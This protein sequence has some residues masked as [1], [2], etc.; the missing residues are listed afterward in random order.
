[1]VKHGNERCA[2]TADGDVVPAEIAN[3]A[4]AGLLGEQPWVADLPANQLAGDMPH[5]MSVKTNEFAPC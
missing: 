4:H 5:R 3:D 1:V 2:L